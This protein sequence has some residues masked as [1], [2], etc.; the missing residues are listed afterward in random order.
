MIDGVLATVEDAIGE[1][2]VADVLP[3]V[4]DRIQLRALGGQ[5]H[6]RD[7]RWHEEF[8]GEMPSSLVVQDN[9]MCAWRDGGGNLGE[10]KVHRVRIT[11]RQHQPG[12]RELYFYLVPIDTLLAGD[13]VQN[14]RPFF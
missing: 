1:P 9:A 7:I 14:G 6:K 12:V 5:W 11:F 8:R 2:I 4:L 10:V 3:D 13:L